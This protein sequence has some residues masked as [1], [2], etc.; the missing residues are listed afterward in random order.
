MSYKR[1][2]VYV[3]KHRPASSERSLWVQLIDMA[4]T[5]ASRSRGTAFGADAWSAS[6]A[7][8]DFRLKLGR[9]TASGFPAGRE[10]G[11]AEMAKA[12]VHAATAWLHATEDHAEYVAVAMEAC[13]EVLDRHLAD[14]RAAEARAT[15][16]GRL[17]ER[18]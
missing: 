12:F 10:V 14:L 16:Q 11:P 2:A 1:A 18:D 13:A 6:E 8:A 7:K 9:V 15:W 5:L 17:G 3:H 4:R